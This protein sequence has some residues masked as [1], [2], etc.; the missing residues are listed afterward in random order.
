MKARYIGDPDDGH[1]GHAV[2]RLFGH[3]FPK[4]R[5]VTITDAKVG[6]QALAA[7]FIVTKLKG[8]AH[9]EVG[10]G[11]AD[12]AEAGLT[13]EEA[14]E[15]AKS[16]PGGSG[17]FDHDHDGK[18]GGSLTKAK[19][20]DALDKLAAKHP[21]KVDYDPGAKRDVLAQ[22]LEELEFELGD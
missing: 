10:D 11:E 6:T 15:A 1:A 4:G 14:A 8:N 21:G 13:A 17:Q 9:F 3:V 20:I 7:D 2:L 19:V 12:P 5:F 22:R 18:P 16:A